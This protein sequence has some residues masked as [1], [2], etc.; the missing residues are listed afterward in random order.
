M[1]I[2]NE[3]PYLTALIV[4]ETKV[5][6]DKLSMGHSDPSFNTSAKKLILSDIA[7]QS[8]ALASFETVKKIAL[9]YDE[10]SIE[11][12]ELTPTLKLRRKIINKKY[13]D[14]IKSLYDD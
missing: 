13:H 6:E 12:T 4:P 11:G 9:I 14:L 10:F 1:V 2:G 5:I 3:R 7:H 8:S